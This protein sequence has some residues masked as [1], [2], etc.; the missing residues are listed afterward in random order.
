MPEVMSIEVDEEFDPRP[1]SQPFGMRNPDGK[2]NVGLIAGIAVAIILVIALIV[3]VANPFGSDPK[4]VAVAKFTPFDPLKEVKAIPL[5]SPSDDIVA[6]LQSSLNDWA[7]YYTTGD[8]EDINGS[9]DLAGKQYAA[10]LK[11]QASILASP[12][13]G[14]PSKIELGTVGNAGKQGN[15]YTLRADITW[16]KP[17]DTPANYKWDV[18]MKKDN[19]SSK[20]LL[21]TTK[22]TKS[23]ATNGLTFCEAVNIVRKLQDDDEVN[24]EFKKL[25]LDDR[26]VAIAAVFDIRLKVWKFVKPAFEESKAPDSV[27]LI[28]DQYSEMLKL[29]EN[30]ETLTDFSTDVASIIND[31]SLLEARSNVEDAAS[32]ECN[33]TDISKR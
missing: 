19:N 18:V 1:P 29:L 32:S 2:L 10:L 25:Q 12:E 3:V 4:P 9:F 13:P 5:Y 15:L 26:K 21:S 16:T 33:G 7:L 8:I 17:G 30:S 11:E 28:V 27:D 6:D 14:L 31:D 20:Y 23:D 24:A 22:T